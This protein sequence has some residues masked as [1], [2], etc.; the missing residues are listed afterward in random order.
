MPRYPLFIVIALL[1]LGMYLSCASR[2]NLKLFVSEGAYRDEVKLERTEFL[3]DT[4]LGDPM[5][6]EKLVRGEGNCLMLITGHRGHILS[7]REEDLISFDRYVQHRLFIQFPQEFGPGNYDLTSISFAQLLGRYE[8]PVEDKIYFPTT[9]TL[10]IDSIPDDKLFGTMD[11]SYENR[12]G[13]L[14]K[15]EGRFRAK[16]KR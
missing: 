10:T 13:E 5:A 9:G 12:K 2:Y 1:S 7:D 4:R 11:A 15:F 14:V 8:L 16:V 3:R 6:A